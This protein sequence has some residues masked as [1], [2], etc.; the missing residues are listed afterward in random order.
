MRLL[1]GSSL[2]DEVEKML[3]PADVPRYGDV[4]L[5]SFKDMGQVVGFADPPVFWL[6]AQMGVV[7][8]DMSLAV[9]VLRC[10]QPSHS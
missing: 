8:V 2:W 10:P 4:V 6:R 9:K 5:S 7:P 3:I 1:A